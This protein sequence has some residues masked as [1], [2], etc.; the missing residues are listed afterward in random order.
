MLPPGSARVEPAAP[1]LRHPAT[2]VAG[3]LPLRVLRLAGDERL[4]ALMRAGHP[5]AVEAVYDRHHRT[6]L[7][8]CRHMLG[9]AEDAEDAVQHTFMAVHRAVGR[10][11]RHRNLQAWLF[12]VARNRCLDMLRARRAGLT[13]GYEEPATERLADEVERRED[14]RALLAD[15]EHL[16]D[17]QRAALVLFELRALS[18]AE[19]GEVIGVPTAKVKALVHQARQSL[20]KTRR[21][22]ETPCTAIREQLATLSGAALRQAPLRR[23]LETCPPCRAFR[24]DVRR[25]RRAMALVLPVVPSATLRSDVLGG[26]IGAGG[27]AGAG[28]ALVVGGLG[29]SVVAKYAAVAL[30]TVGGATATVTAV[31]HHDARSPDKK[32]PV[33]RLRAT[34]PTTAPTAQRSG[35]PSSRRPGATGRAR[36]AEPPRSVRATQRTRV[37]A[38]GHP[39]PAAKGPPSRGTASP[40]TPTRSSAADPEPASAAGTSQGAAHRSATGAAHAA[41]PIHA[42][43]R[44]DPGINARG[45]VLGNGTTD[46]PNAP[47][48]VPSPGQSAGGKPAQPATPTPPVQPHRPTA[49]PPNH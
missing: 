9:D 13:G 32:E 43:G 36:A 11:P 22:R 38:T 41:T 2:G 30:L 25:Q 15:I 47:A 34:P 4:L 18:H 29:K 33:A 8:F 42:G 5:V 45:P 1:A 10:P 44:I 21:A 17:D 28:T 37:P 20:I 6:L 26:L 35:V 3:L 24:D 19:I 16:P 12:T 48:H 40:S 27:G 31:R 23:H 14:L 49:D 46:P 7:S 39:A